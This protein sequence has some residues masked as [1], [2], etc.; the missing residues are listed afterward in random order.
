[1]INVDTNA[2]PT[3]A[4]H[5]AV[6]IGMDDEADYRT[7]SVLALVSL[8]LGL[9]APLCLMA[10]LLFALPIAG[11]ALALLAIRRIAVSDG[12]L[13][14]RAAAMIGLALSIASMTA[15]YTHTTL[16]QELLS[17]QS[18]AVALEWIALLQAGKT[19]QAFEQTVASKQGPPPPAPAG[20][21][22]ATAQPQVP[23]I[24]TFRQDPVVQFLLDH[25]QG[26]SVRYVRDEAFDPGV[27]G[28]ASIQQQF[29]I[30]APKATAGGGTTSIQLIMKRSRGY[31]GARAQWL[32]SAYKSDDVASHPS[33]HD[34]SAAHNH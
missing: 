12:A 30:G 18:R 11:V 25:A 32:V 33:E 6:V 15:A 29:V 34:H 5:S 9:T 17:W 26:A 19:E 22:E 31:N 27:R 14:G 10:P 13:I 7:I 21:P 23:P 3:A 4:T 24:D 2:P 1:M 28:D 20:A 8:V 16:V